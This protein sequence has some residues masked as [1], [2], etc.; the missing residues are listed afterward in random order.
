[1][2]QDLGAQIAKLNEVIPWI[3]AEATHLKKQCAVARQ[4]LRPIIVRYNI[5]KTLRQ[6]RSHQ[7]S[8]DLWPLA[9]LLVGPLVSAGCVFVLVHGLTGHPSVAFAFSVA[10]AV[11]ASGMLALCL[12]IPNNA[13]LV[14]YLDDL[15]R[16]VK[17][18]REKHDEIRT[19]YAAVTKT[20]DARKQQRDQILASAAYERKKLLQRNW[21]AMRD[22]KWEEY[23]AEVC[24]ALGAHVELTK[25]TGDQGVDL[26]VQFGGRRIAVQAKGYYNSV[27][28]SAVQEAA[29]G[30]AH[31]RCNG[32]AVMTN[33]RFT[34]SAGDLAASNAC[35]LIGE[36]EFPAFV[37]GE[38]TL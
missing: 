33:S 4:N 37:R 38:I 18:H 14:K 16:H 15:E 28:N 10:A 5:Y 26:V 6:L 1:M 25:T 20:L 13:E 21:K 19:R 12:F 31:Y 23:L 7:A 30:M 11:F 9:V 35:T 32:C 17:L 27:S 22:T 8:F 34:K 29:A 3:T 36:T 24:R 2:S